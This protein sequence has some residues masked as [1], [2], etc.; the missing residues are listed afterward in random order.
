MTKEAIS[1]GYIPG[2]LLRRTFRRL[3][4]RQLREGVWVALMKTPL[5]ADLIVLADPTTRGRRVKR[6]TQLIIEGFP[7]SGNTYARAAFEHA[8]GLDVPVSSHMHSFRSIQKGVRRGIPTIALVRAPDKVLGSLLQFNPTYDAA[9]IL[10]SYRAFHQLLREHVDTIVVADF[11]EVV[12]DF[13]AVTERVNAR[14]GTSFVPYVKT[15]ESEEAVFAAVD[16]VAM[17]HEGERFADAVSRP[18]EA[19]LR[20]DDVLKGLTEAERLDLAAAETEYHEL[21]TASDRGTH[22]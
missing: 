6:S 16:A 1:T 18:S 4:P 15:P 22:P 10:K 13:G 9:E 2:G 19:R 20:A 3:V 11:T 5:V 12:A 7:R 14:Y 8:N 17:A 21:L